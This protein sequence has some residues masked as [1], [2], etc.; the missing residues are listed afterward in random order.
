MK[1]KTK[2]IEEKNEN[3][4]IGFHLDWISLG[5]KLLILIGFIFMIIFVVANLNKSKK[6]T[7]FNKNIELMRAGAYNYFKEKENRPVNENEEIDISLNDMIDSNIVEELNVSKK[8]VCDRNISGIAVTKI[9]DVKYNLDV[10]LLCGE[11]EKTENYTLNYNSLKKEAS[12]NVNESTNNSGENLTTMYEL[13]RTVQAENSYRCPNG[14]TLIGTKCYSNVSV[15]KASAVPIYDVKP[16]K[17]VL[18]SYH[19]EEIN[20]EYADLIVT[21]EKDLIKCPEGFTLEN[22]NCQK[23]EDIKVKNTKKYIC[24]EGYTLNGTKCIKK[25]ALNTIETYRCKSGT[26]TSDNRCKITTE[27]TVSCKMGTFDSSKKMCYVLINATPN[28][29]DWKNMGEIKTKDKKSNTNLVYYTYL[30]KT[31]NG[32]YRY[33][34]MTRKILNYTCKVGS[35]SGNGKCRYYHSSY[36]KYSCKSGT[37]N[38]S[39]CISYT[40][41]V[42]VISTGNCPS[43]YT[44][45][46][47]ACVKKVNAAS[48]ISKKYYCNVGSIVTKDKKCMTITEPIVKDG[49]KVYSCPDGYEM[50]GKSSRA[51]CRKKNVTPGYYYCNDDNAVLDN[52]RCITASVSTFKGYKCPSGYELAGNYCYKYTKSETLQATKIAGGILNEE[53]IW[54][55]SSKLDGWT[56]TGNTKKV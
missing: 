15:L 12:S 50:I 28:Y 37:L 13:K 19:K 45:E 4:E 27:A 49:G 39:S 8:V 47:N 56:F 26:L 9:N 35:Y 54:S 51:T 36:S 44:K 25:L 43:G 16:D 18:A 22:D 11:M 14:F 34:M 23:I 32:L 6:N 42:K 31:S 21:D 5:I 2:N 30:G 20:Y 40:N 46:N 1:K 17:N 29:S 55:T 53:Y 38:G 52:G 41:A 24:P 33:N 3:E 7:T 10:H 48:T